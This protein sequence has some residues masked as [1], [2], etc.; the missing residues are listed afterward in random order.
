MDKYTVLFSPKAY[1]DIDKIYA[2]IANELVAIGAA[3][4]LIDEIEQSILGLDVLPYRGSERKVG[5][6][7]N[8]GYRQIYVKNFVIVYRVD[9]R[10]KQVVIVTV[11]YTPS[12]F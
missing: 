3:E 2:Y 12:Q 7:A 6:F 11:R 4:N 9:E 1:K 8:K 10:S 5:T